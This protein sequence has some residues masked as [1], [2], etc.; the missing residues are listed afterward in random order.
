MV[1]SLHFFFYI[2]RRCMVCK[3][4]IRAS[5]GRHDYDSIMREVCIDF[6]HLIILILKTDSQS[7]KLEDDDCLEV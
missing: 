2:S 1:E 5:V 7:I 4:C 3:L 6:L